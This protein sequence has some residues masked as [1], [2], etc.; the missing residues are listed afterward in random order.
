METVKSFVEWV[1][2]REVDS[3]ELADG[4]D[5]VREGSPYFKH[6][7]F[8]GPVGDIKLR[9]RDQLYLGKTLENLLGSNVF[10]VISQTPTDDD[11]L[12]MPN[13]NNLQF[14]CFLD[15]SRTTASK[16]WNIDR[17]GYRPHAAGGVSRFPDS[18]IAENLED[19]KRLKS[20]VVVTVDD[21]LTAAQKKDLG[22]RPLGE[23]W[24]RSA[25]RLSD[26]PLLLLSVYF[27]V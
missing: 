12:V 6:T 18:V 3:K 8:D 11:Q 25:S 16:V 19:W 9:E 26:L 14:S 21:S 13:T 10:S 2:E 17:D 22:S 1:V 23:Y 15:S 4:W 24:P 20:E 7:S 5:L 27:H